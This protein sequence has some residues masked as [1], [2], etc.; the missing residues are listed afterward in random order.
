MWDL[1]WKVLEE[2][3]V[4]TQ[5]L[6]CQEAVTNPILEEQREEEVV[7]SPGTWDIWGSENHKRAGW[8]EKQQLPLRPARAEARGERKWEKYL[9]SPLLSPSGLLPILPFLADSIQPGA[10]WRGSSWGIEFAQGC[11]L[12][13]GAGKE[14]LPLRA[15]RP[16][17]S[18]PPFP[19]LHNWW[20]ET[21]PTTSVYNQFCRMRS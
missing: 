12:E 21:L 19:S 18:G 16:M 1:V 13:Y 4:A 10:I 20:I 17:T 9:A 3:G 2:H 11:P 14:G 6:A 8:Q 15:K 5:R 7:Q